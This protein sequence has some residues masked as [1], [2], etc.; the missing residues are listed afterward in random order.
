LGNIPAWVLGE[1]ASEQDK[2]RVLVECNFVDDWRVKWPPYIK[3]ATVYEDRIEH[4]TDFSALSERYDLKKGQLSTI[5]KVMDMIEEFLNFFDHSDEAIVVAYGY[6]HFFEEAHNKFRA[7][8]DSDPDFK[9]QFFTWMLQGKFTKMKQVTQ[10]GEVRDNEDAWDRIRKDDAD[11]VKAAIYIVDGEK[12]S[13]GG[14]ADGEKKILG[15][16]KQLRRLKEHEIAS[17]SPETLGELQNTLGQIVAMAQ[18]VLFGGK[19][20]VKVGKGTVRRES[21]SEGGKGSSEGK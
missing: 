6:Y 5:V 8:L 12:L 10:L 4:G 19:V 11:A 15:L 21:A 7:K 14:G 20:H 9:E 2:Q 17:I 18:A 3:A 1:D 13:G 16:V